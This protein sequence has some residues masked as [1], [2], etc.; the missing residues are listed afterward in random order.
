MSST[1]PYLF[2]QEGLNYLLNI[3][4]RAAV[5]IPN[6]LYVGLFTT[7]WTNITSSGYSNIAATLNT[8]TFNI[9]EV[10]G[11]GASGYNRLAI[12]G[13]GWNAS[14]TGSVTIGSNT[15][16]VQQ[17]TYSGAATF[18]CTSGTWS[19]IYGIFIATSGQTYSQSNGA[20]MTVLW[21]APFADLNPVT[22]ASGDSL[23]VT[24]TWQSAP[25]P[26]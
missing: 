18:T 15:I 9:L 22:L 3:S 8:G 24:P 10:S 1:S 23:A 7:P 14:T 17:T 6:P 2:P 26:A 21:Y 4:P 19:S 16:S 11:T 13:A 5:N 12:S 25:Y 20:S